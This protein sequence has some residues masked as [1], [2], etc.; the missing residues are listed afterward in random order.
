MT[1][2]SDPKT[3]VL[4][5]ASPYIFRAYYSLPESIKSP[6]GARVGAVYGF[7]TFLL[8]LIADEKPTHFAVAFD[9]NLNG[10]FR[11]DEYPEYKAQRQDPPADLVSQIDPCL[12]VAEAMGITPFI[13]ERYE[14]DDLIATVLARA[15]PEPHRA[16][17]VSSDKDLTQLVSD[18]VTFLDFANETRYTPA[19]VREKFGVRPDQI[20]DLL[21]LAGDPV[22]NIPGVPGIGRKTAVDILAAYDTLENVYAHLEEIPFSKLR[23]AK[24][25]ASK[26]RER[27]ELAFL[28]KRLA[29]VATDAPVPKK[30]TLDDLA[31]RGADMA[32]V[33]PLFDRLGFKKIKDR[34]AGG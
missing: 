6:D 22:D 34:V 8:K 29:T 7:V 14:A 15:I 25:I 32:V 18:R 19:E 17:V 24:S 33:E 2:P 4:V 26:L 28:S 30:L 12:E 5:D 27:R 20:V 31:Y 16:L 3:V 21:A 1:E 10:S 23:A 11:N 9:R 13:D